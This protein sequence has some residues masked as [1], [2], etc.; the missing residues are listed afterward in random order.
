MVRAP[1]PVWMVIFLAGA[2]TLAAQS[3]D[4][5]FSTQERLKLYVQR[6]YSW[7]RM[8]L[9]GVDTAIDH[10]FFRSREWK[11]DAPG[12]FQ[13]YG[14]SFGQRVVRNS[15]E[16][17][18]GIALGED[19]RFQPSHKAGLASRLSFAA[20]NAVL[21]R[22]DSGSRGFSY[23]RLAAAVGGTVLSSAW[24]PCRISPAHYANEISS[25]YLSSLQNSL[26]TEFTPDLLR[27]GKRVHA[28]TLGKYVH[29][30]S[31][32]RAA[33]AAWIARLFPE[34]AKAVEHSQ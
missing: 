3:A 2:D 29:M 34:Q 23:A 10:V 28:A 33:P 16:L 15:L 17:G 27:L 30:D 25:F 5:G 21:A 18:A 22:H 13:R 31:H 6:T 4:P 19:T 32:P 14:S 20:S 8:T 11:P 12:F 24:R 7:Q 9:L 1:V 26:L